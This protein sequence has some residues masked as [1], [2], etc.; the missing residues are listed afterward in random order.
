VSR[1]LN[2]RSYEWELADRTIQIETS[3][4]FGVR[5]DSDGAIVEETYYNLYLVIVEN[6]SKEAVYKAHLFDV[7]DKIFYDGKWHSYL[8][9]QLEKRMTVPDRFLLNS[10]NRAYIDD[11]YGEYAI[12]TEEDDE[13]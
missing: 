5:F 12:R 4:G 9:F 11:P 2:Q 1:E 7:P 8:D 10:T 6:A 13:R 3:R